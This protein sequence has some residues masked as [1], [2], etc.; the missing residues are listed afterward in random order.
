M[1][2]TCNISIHTTGNTPEILCAVVSYFMPDNHHRRLTGPMI[3]RTVV[4]L[5]ASAFSSDRNGEVLRRRAGAILAWFLSASQKF[6]LNGITPTHLSAPCLAPHISLPPLS[7]SHHPPITILRL[8]LPSH[9]EGQLVSSNPKHSSS[10]E[11]AS[12]P[13]RTTC[14]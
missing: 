5:A 6:Q 14:P 9:L 2:F 13:C 11:S 4:S 7:L 10:P 12:S 1:Y 8:L 3:S